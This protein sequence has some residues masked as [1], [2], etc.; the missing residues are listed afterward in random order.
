VQ[1]SDRLVVAVV[2]PC[3]NAAGYVR[4]A[5][6][7]ALAQ[8]DVAVEVV[9][10]DDGSCDDLDRVLETFTGTIRVIRHETN[11]GVSAARNTGI[12]NCTGDVIAFLDADDWW[13][14][15]FLAQLLPLVKEGQAVAYDNYIVDESEAESTY[16]REASTECQARTEPENSWRASGEGSQMLLIPSEQTR[17]RATLR[18]NPAWSR[19]PVAVTCENLHLLFEEQSPPKLIVH[20]KDCKAIGGFDEQMHSIEDFYLAVKLVL[21]GVRLVVVPEPKGFY[22]HRGNSV[23]RTIERE[24]RKRT[25]ALLD[26]GRMYNKLTEEPNLPRSIQRICKARVAYYRARYVDACIKQHLHE[27]RLLPLLH[28]ALLWLLIRSSGAIF[29]FKINGLT[30]RLQP[31]DTVPRS[32]LVGRAG[33][34]PENEFGTTRGTWFRS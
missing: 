24:H 16:A 15:D 2:I 5:V 30:H 12:A 28:P 21:S 6:R 8:R 14:N 18:E 9:L 32:G 11:R 4:R 33:P 3:F 23:L 7:S 26:K 25:A 20:R 1:K 31:R 34:A 29:Q 22:L 10:V 17:R 13:P 27:G 19:G